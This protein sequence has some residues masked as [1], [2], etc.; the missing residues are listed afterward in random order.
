MR[1]SY[2]LILFLFLFS[3]CQNK[4]LNE[5]QHQDEPGL[6]STPSE[7][8]EMNSAIEKAKISFYIFEKAF[9]SKQY[10]SSTFTVKMRFPT[11]KGGEHLWLTNIEAVDSDYLGIVNNQPEATS[12]VKLGDKIK[13]NKNQLSDWMYS[14][15]GNLKGGYTIK[16]IRSRMSA[17]ERKQFDS[18]F[19]YKIED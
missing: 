16:V 7:D 3:A 12:A 11:S 10:D 15:Q 18:T 14:E 6:Y 8:H 1:K 5:T 17:E 4:V 13:I 9:K 19:P 2:F